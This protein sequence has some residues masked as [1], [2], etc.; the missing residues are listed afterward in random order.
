MN[1]DPGSIIQTKRNQLEIFIVEQI[2]GPGI[3]GYMYVNVNDNELMTKSITEQS[4]IDYHKEVINIVPAAVYSSGILFPINNSNVMQDDPIT[5]LYDKEPVIDDDLSN[6][7]DNDEDSIDEVE[8]IQIDQMYPNSMGLSCCF[9]HE[10]LNSN[11]ISITVHARY[12][13]KINSKDHNYNSQY[14]VLC[15]CEIE[16]MKLFLTEND[17]ERFIRI[18]KVNLNTILLIEPNSENQIKEIR[19]TV[20]AVRENKIVGLKHICNK[21][22]SHLNIKHSSQILQSCYNKMKYET[23]NNEE[24]KE[25]YEAAQEIENLETQISYVDNLI[26]INDSKS[27]GL[28]QSNPIEIEVPFPEK[29][30]VDINKKIICSYQNRSYGI[31]KDIY[32]YDLGDGSIASLSINLQIS[33][34]TRKIN[35]LIYL[36]AQLVN[37]STPFV[38]KEED[39][40]YYSA[41]NEIINQRSF[42]GVKLS[43]SNKHLKP[44]NTIEIDPKSNYYEEDEVNKF[45]YRQFEDFGVGHGCSVKWS[46]NNIDD[47]IV[48]TEYIPVCDTPE[49]D[50]I[51]RNKEIVVSQSGTYESDIF[52]KNND[53]LE[54][55]WL[56]VFSKVSNEEV[57]NGLTEFIE[58]YGEWIEIKRKKYFSDFSS[59][60]IA[61][62]E[63][64]KCQD[65]KD[66]MSRNLD[67]FLKGK[68]NVQN[69]ESFRLMNTAMFMQLWHS[70]KAENDEVKDYFEGD[71]KG[72]NID[73]Y[74]QADD[75][76]F[77]PGKA[78]AWRPFQLAFILL[79][80]DGIFNEREDKKWE[81]RNEY[82]DLVWF[83]TGG[84]K[85]EAYLGIIALT[86]INRRRLYGD[87]GGGTAAIMRYTLRLLTLQQFQRA[88]IV[89]MA[90]E[91]IR[92]WQTYKLGEEPIFIGMWV[93]DNSLP[94]KMEDLEKEFQKLSDGNESKVPY[95]NCPWCKSKLSPSNQKENNIEHIH[96]YNRLLLK[97]SNNMCAF[98]Y[99]RPSKATKIQG[100]IPVSLCDEEIYQHPPSL[101]FGT[102]DKF[103]QLAHKVTDDKNKRNKDSRRLFGRGNWEKG[104]P[105]NGYLPPDIIIQ[106]EMHLLLGPLGSSVA[107]FESAI[108]QLCR[109]E[110]G[111]RP[112]IITSTATTRNT[113]L[114]IM[115]LFD[116]KVNIF[117][118]SGVECDDS[119][120]TFYKR[121]FH[122][123][124]GNENNYLSKRRY[125]GI[126]PTGHTQIWMQMR[127]AAI[128]LTHRA[129]FELHMLRDKTPLDF[130]TYKSFEN[131]MDYYH[132]IVSYFNSL[133]ELG[134]TES[135]I[136]T[137]IKK[138]VRRVFNRIIRPN[139][140]AHALYTYSINKGELTGRL[141]GQEVKSELSRISNNWKSNKRFAN[142]NNGEFNIGY[143]PPDFVV[144]T[145]MISV[146]IDISRLNTLIINSMPRNIAEYIQASSRVARNSFGLV[147]T[148]HHPFRARD[149][150]HYEKFIEFHRKMYS[151][152]EPISITPFTPKAIERYLGLYLATMIRQTTEFVNRK[153]AEKITHLSDEKLSELVSKLSNYFNERRIHLDLC[154]V[155]D[156]IKNLLKEKNINYINKWINDAILEWKLFSNN[157]IDQG[158]Q[159]VF[160]HKSN[161]GKILQEQLYIEIDE[162]EENINRKKWQVPMSLRVIEPEAALKIELK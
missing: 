25:L 143:T 135:Q 77:E 14:G 142:K 138:E 118:K 56:S 125:L 92:R 89:T 80:L 57:L 147:I 1:V 117:P 59:K 144:A 151:H 110:D 62:Q 70:I 91:L 39:S 150:S 113:D 90:L 35:D 67:T 34:E 54:F 8:T 134:K 103:A 139:K 152:V 162:Y 50:P 27:Y 30:P 104:K 7:K 69:M 99:N 83:P 13:T 45:I 17:L 85:T 18:K 130:E 2:L 86:I 153:S 159:V 101:L 66:R 123:P 140:L 137:Y 109:R 15:E 87:R 6:D 127:L 11:D 73:F 88:T 161:K 93:G 5:N 133:R 81:K 21:Y 51:P 58:K 106:D 154:N 74:E 60:N 84:G 28:W 72:F 31:L 148:V 141:S 121:K 63:L 37:T 9:S 120:F 41:F 19:N 78:A 24:R 12:Y 146:G 40:R 26:E 29:I 157:T 38:K 22:F 79:N 155:N 32:K 48:E 42:F 115:A 129:I 20:R 33:K 76:L 43:I 16:K 111:T 97:C 95:D 119:F 10:I 107:L 68:N 114:Q 75:H 158:K 4:P 98:Y 105:S 149:I 46:K 145:N 61:L 44:Y 53:P 136:D 52:L 160:N 112:K 126:L 100:P 124:I 47:I 116:R 3:C 65:D 71:F 55:K 96:L 156:I 23:I 94:N 36:K 102:V 64:K 108:D 82:V 132:T 122:D 128:L 49:V 131:A